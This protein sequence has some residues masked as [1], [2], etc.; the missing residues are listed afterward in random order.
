M[1]DSQIEGQELEGTATNAPDVADKNITA[2]PAVEEN[3]PMSTR[4]AALKAFE[5][6][7]GK[8]TEPEKKPALPALDK[9]KVDKAPAKAIDPVTG[10][11]IEPMKA[12]GG[13]TPA[14]REKWG[15]IDPQVQ[16]FIIDRERDMATRLQD[17]AEERKLAKE[18][19]DIAAPYEA[20]FRQ[21]STSATAHVKELLNLSFG[22]NTGNPVQKAHIIDQLIRH[23]NPDVE[24]L[25]ALS[26]GHAPKPSDAPKPVD[27]NAEV[28]KALAQRDK[29]SQEKQ[30]EAIHNAFAS[31]PKNEF[32]KDVEELMGRAIHAGLVTGNTFEELYQNAYNWACKNHS[33]VSGILASRTAVQTQ[34]QAQLPLNQPRPTQGVKPSLGSGK[35]AN[36]QPTFRTNRDAAL[37]AWDKLSGN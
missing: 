14:L 24:A 27:V 29:E 25:M 31:D 28:Q 3:K 11:E 19:R 30:V 16:K 35:A 37:A 12:P 5:K 6:L 9:P 18:F 15:T 10:R 4:D 21:H 17:T 32:F 33:E 8:G 1:E 36:P 26:R 20:M 2:T 34:H 13:W 22:L 23:F 7:E